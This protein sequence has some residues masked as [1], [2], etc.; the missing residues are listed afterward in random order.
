M[1]R[2]YLSMMALSASCWLGAVNLTLQVDMTNQ[3]VSG[4]GVHVAGDFNSP[5]YSPGVTNASYVN[6]TPAAVMLDN[7]G[8]GNVYSYT[9]AMNPGIY[10]FK[11]LNG[12][13]WGT[14]ESVPEGCQVGGG[15]GNRYVQVGATDVTYS[16]CYGECAACGERAVS[17]TVDVSPLAVVNPAGIGVYIDEWAAIFPLVNFN[18]ASDIWKGVVGIGTNDMIEYKFVNGLLL[19]NTFEVVPA[20]CDNAGGNRELATPDP[21]NAAPT[22]FWEACTWAEPVEIIFNVDM[23]LACVASGEVVNIMGSFPGNG[24]ATAWP[25]TDDGDGTWSYTAQLL[26]G[27]YEYKFRVGDGGWESISNRQLVVVDAMPETLPNV[28]FNSADP[29]TGNAFSPADVTFKLNPGSN[30]VPVGQFCWVMGD[31]TGW[32]GGALQMTGPDADNVYSV[33]IPDFCPQSGAYKFA[34]GESNLNT[35]TNWLEESADFSAIGGCGV[36]NGTFSDNRVF[37]RID[38]L[39][40]TLCFTFNECNSCIIAVE[41][42]EV[43]ANLNVYPVPAE[44]MLNISFDAMLAQNISISLSNNMGQIVMTH[45]AGTLAGNSIVQLNVEHLAAGIYTLQMSNG[46]AVQSVL[47]AVK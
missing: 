36:D 45:N 27:S 7:G 44:G 47:V 37:T 38:E 20:E 14:E 31:F 2:I 13:A 28:C 9:F 18:A 46:S 6:W 42:N 22:V 15:N 34:I 39:P 25:M 32:Q 23:T 3:T 5:E 19:E 4:D 35:G 26:P 43:V 16:V 17:F 8:S 33:T 21:M 29:C 24:W 40:L 11:F 41:E 1:K 10:T 12:N 30:P